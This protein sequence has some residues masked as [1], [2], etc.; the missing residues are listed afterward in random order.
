LAIDWPALSAL[1]VQLGFPALTQRDS[2][3]RLCAGRS[4]PLPNENTMGGH[5]RGRGGALGSI[6]GG[7][8]G[9]EADR[10][11]AAVARYLLRSR[12]RF[13]GILYAFKIAEDM[14]RRL[15][16]QPHGDCAPG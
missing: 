2:L 6:D 1:F 10:E 15:I 8:E 13:L 7:T 12:T 16:V 5:W 4:A 3:V 14:R 9:E 11:A